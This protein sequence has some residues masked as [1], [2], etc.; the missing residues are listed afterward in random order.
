MSITLLR[1]G[2]TSACT[3][4][5]LRGRRDDPLTEEGWQQ[6]RTAAA[7]HPHHTLPDSDAWQVI[8][9]SPLIRCAAFAHELAQVRGLPLHMD[10]RLI[11]LDFGVWEGQSLD[12]LMQDAENKETLRRFWENPWQQPP[13]QGET[14]TAFETRIRAAWQSLITRHAGQ[15]V[16]VITHGGVIRLLLCAARGL[17]RHQLLQIEVTHASLHP[18]EAYPLPPLY[19]HE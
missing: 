2:A 15:R 5:V 17:P 10:E 7:T 8:I 13:P 18:L 6:M 16:L 19:D 11:E 14:L 9:S 1:H 12:T 4:G 3:H